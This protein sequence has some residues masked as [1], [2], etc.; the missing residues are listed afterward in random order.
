[1]IKAVRRILSVIAV[2]TAI[3]GALKSFFQWIARNEEDNHEI[4]TDEEERE[5]AL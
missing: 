2:F 5:D 4:F 3:F 1:M